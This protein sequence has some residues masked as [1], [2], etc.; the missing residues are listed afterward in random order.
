MFKRH[1]LSRL[2]EKKTLESLQLTWNTRIQKTCISRCRRVCAR[3]NDSVVIRKDNQIMNIWNSSIMAN[4][5]VD[6]GCQSPRCLCS[7]DAVRTTPTATMEV[8]LNL[9]PIHIYMQGTDRSTTYRLRYKQSPISKSHGTNHR[10]VIDEL[11]EVPLMGLSNDT[12]V[13]KFNL[14]R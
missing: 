11:K 13:Q 1:K 9:P 14:H 10:Q 4:S 2:R 3:N 5:A 8:I 6:K 12:M 7:T